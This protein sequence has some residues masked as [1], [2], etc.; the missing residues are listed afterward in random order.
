[1]MSI[2][3]KMFLA[4]LASLPLMASAEHNE[5]LE[6]DD[7]EVTST[8]DSRIINYPATV[9]SFS[10]KQIQESINATTSAQ[11][12]K[13]LPSFQVRE[14]F[15]GDR[16][17]IIAGRTVGTLSSAQSML[18]ADGVLLSNLLGNSFA[19]PPRWGLV[20]PDEIEQVSMMY[21]PF[22]A[23]YAGNSF[24]GVVSIKTKMPT[25]FEAHTNVQMF[26]QNFDL[27]GTDLNLTGEHLSASLGNKWNDLSVLVSA[28]Y[29]KN[30]G[31]PMDFVVQDVSAGGALAG[32]AVTGAFL[33]KN[34][35]NLPRNVFGAISM[36]RPEQTNLKFK[37]AYDFTDTVKGTYTLGLWN[38]SN[39]TDVESYI[40]DA[41]GNAVYNNRVVL[42]GRSYN[43]TGFNPAEAEAMHVMQAFDLKSDTKGFFDWQLTLSDY[44]YQQD[45][46]SQSNLSTSTTTLAAGNPYITRTG[47]VTDLSGTG[48]TIF[49]VRATFRPEANYSG[50]HELDIGYHIDEYDLE[51]N[52]YNTTDWTRGVKGSLNNSSRG[53]TRTQAIYLQDRWQLNPNWA[54]TFGG[55]TE[56]WEAM[57]GRNQNTIAGT[58]RTGNY[59]STSETKFSPKLSISFEPQ[60]A[61]GFRAAF[62]QA[63]RFPTVS[64]LYQQ[65]T[66]NNAIV[67]NNPNLKPEEVL[68]A[69][70][71]AERRFGNGL[72]RASLFSENKYDALISQTVLNGRA[73]PF[74]TGTCN[75]A[76]G[77]TFIQNL[78]HIRTRG[79]ELSTEWQDVLVHGLDLLGSLTLTEGEILRNMNDRNTEGKK[80]TRIPRQMFKFVGTYHQ[81]QNITYSLAARYSGRQYNN[82]DNSDVNDDTYI[83]ASEFFF[84]DLKANYQFDKRWAASVGVDNVNNYQ[85]YVRHPYPQRTGYVQVK[86][87]Y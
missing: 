21:G 24:G 11:T 48:W 76:A 39:R 45:K 87:D 46:N 54:V 3:K 69:E 19:F 84:V 83:A 25:Q 79:L 20:G 32:T 68:S 44:D 64:E 26:R 66:Q 27:Y 74:G 61:W 40:K 2:H 82:L 14:R 35:R 50:K 49:D 72:I 9:E 31:Q 34:D 56:H 42:N 78:D 57:D 8:V 77:C 70:L 75:V 10:K 17:G 52:T 86:F 23:M 33:D 63:Y 30:E 53:T 59:G 36:E 51:S 81:G 43:L 22:S 29:L 58:L 28:D 5:S 60:P 67:E 71:T 12:M 4:V 80:P 62:G 18:Y 55:R 73:V 37:A 6:L 7:I 38:L 16:N 47:R 1:M 65:V 85:G 13:Y 41:S 15:I